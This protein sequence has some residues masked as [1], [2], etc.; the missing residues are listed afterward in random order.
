MSAGRNLKGSRSTGFTL[1]KHH[2]VIAASHVI[3]L[4][5]AHS[6]GGPSK[7]PSPPP[8]WGR[9]MMEREGQTLN[10]ISDISVLQQKSTKYATAL[11]QYNT[12]KVESSWTSSNSDTCII[13][14]WYHQTSK[15]L[16]WRSLNM[17]YM[18]TTSHPNWCRQKLQPLPV[19]VVVSSILHKKQTTTCINLLWPWIHRGIMVIS[20]L[21]PVFPFQTPRK[22]YCAFPPNKK[23]CGS[24]RIVG[25][26]LKK[27]SCENT[28]K[29]SWV[30]VYTTSTL[31]GQLHALKQLKVGVTVKRLRAHANPE[32]LV[33]EFNTNSSLRA[34]IWQSTTVQWFP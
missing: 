32:L 24:A 2:G 6:Q 5:M 3:V 7:C 31:F 34:K 22:V 26:Q 15:V 25:F 16:F 33:V 27:T 1:L 30:D 17:R 20:T 14:F 18:I 8:E 9:E 21:A 19:A 28:V 4:P 29:F 23:A 13:H 10:N 12:D 11:Q